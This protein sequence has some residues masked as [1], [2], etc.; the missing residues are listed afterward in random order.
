MSST[1]E[2]TR[3]PGAATS[4]RRKWRS[5]VSSPSIAGYV[6]AYTFLNYQVYG[7]FMSGNTTQAGLNA[8]RGDLAGRRI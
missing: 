7:S 2:A 5:P 8:G 1:A 4:R 3:A 6:D